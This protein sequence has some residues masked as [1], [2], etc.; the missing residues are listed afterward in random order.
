MRRLTRLFAIPLALIFFAACQGT[1]LGPVSTPEF[2]KTKQPPPPPA[3]PVI[4][5]YTTKGLVVMNADGSNQTTVV[6]WTQNFWEPSGF[7]HW[8]PDGTSILFGV[9]WI[10]NVSV[11][12][13]T[14]VGGNLHQIPITL[15]AGWNIGF[16]SDWSP[17]G[18]SIVMTAYDQV[19]NLQAESR[20]YMVAAAGGMPTLV[21][22]SPVGFT[23]EWPQLSPD[24]SKLVFVDA[25]Q[26]SG[27]NKV[28]VVFDRGSSTRTVIDS[29]DGLFVRGPR[30]SHSGDRIAYSRFTRNNPQYIY[31]IPATGGTP[32]SLGVIGWY[33]AWSPDDAILAYGPGPAFDGI[34]ALTLAT[35]VTTPL[36]P[37]GVF[38]DWRR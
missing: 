5:F 19:T 3:A 12:N 26:S 35:G 8:S 17:A 9:N 28:L 27:F 38:P 22:A 30:W 14:P 25:G 37:T 23:A 4:T 15:P 24:G 18:D 13:G 10:V 32:T 1:P 21:Y 36:A 7:P 29:S 11:V 31:T 6:R 20:I 34:N 33:P 16:D 2:S